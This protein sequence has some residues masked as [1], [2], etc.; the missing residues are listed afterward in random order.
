MITAH[1]TARYALRLGAA[2]LLVLPALLPTGALALDRAT[3][4]AIT[5][6]GTGDLAASGGPSE[7]VEP[8]IQY[9]DFVAHER[10]VINFVPGERVTVGFTPRA[11]ETWPIGGKPPRALPGGSA[12]G[13]TMRAAPQGSVW[14]GTPAA[15]RAN[16]NPDP[17]GP[18]ADAGLRRGTTNDSGSAPV[19][20]AIGPTMRAT[21]ASF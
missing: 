13:K 5:V 4:G 9:T 7:L 11:G 21:T 17:K 8:T 14:A 15:P 18:P 6:P 19:D 3:D 20:G 16:A 2:A 10:D 12:T 1:R